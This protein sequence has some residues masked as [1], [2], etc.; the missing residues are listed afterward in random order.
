VFLTEYK[1]IVFYLRYIS[2][3][4]FCIPMTQIDGKCDSREGYDGN[5][6]E[7]G[8]EDGDCID[9][10]KFQEEHPDCSIFS[11]VDPADIGGEL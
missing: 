4:L 9:F 10:N 7:C 5:T 8:F 1:V 11:W 2:N 6:A 3:S